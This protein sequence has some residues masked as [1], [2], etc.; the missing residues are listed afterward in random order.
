VLSGRP[1][2]ILPH[3]RSKVR[4]RFCS[5]SAS[6]STSC[7]TWWQRTP[8]AD[9]VRDFGLRCL[10]PDEELFRIYCYHCTPYGE[11]E[12]HPLT[13]VPIDFSASSTFSSMHRLLRDLSLKNN[14]AF[15]AGELSF[16]GWVIKKRSAEEIAATGRPLAT[17]DFAPDLKRKRVDMKIGLTWPG[18]PPGPSW[19]GWCWSRAT[20]T[21]CPP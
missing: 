10:H 16:D 14:V 5:I 11:T 3:R 6:S 19:S 13:R 18:C 17:T 20:A 1:A 8:T 15:R 7:T 21:S 12:T 4:R 9:E 2:F